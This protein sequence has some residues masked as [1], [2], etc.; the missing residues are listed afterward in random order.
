M[1]ICPSFYPFALRGVFDMKRVIVLAAMVMAMSVASAD[2]EEGN[3]SKNSL[4]AFGLSGLQVVS[5]DAGMSVRGARSFAFVGG[6]SRSSF[7]GNNAAHGYIAGASHRRGP[8]SASGGSFAVS[9]GGTSLFGGAFFNV[10]S[11]G[12]AAASAGR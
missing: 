2:A 1:G 5:D 4:S 12:G 3:V 7:F 11:A 6:V 9:G 10:G 8:T